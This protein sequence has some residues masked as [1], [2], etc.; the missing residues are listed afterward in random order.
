MASFPTSAVKNCPCSATWSVR[1]TSCQVCAKTRSRSSS[2]YTGSLYRRAGM[3]DARAMLGSKGKTRG[4]R[5]ERIDAVRGARSCLRSLRSLRSLAALLE[6]H[7]GSRGPTAPQV[8]EVTEVNEADD[9]HRRPH[10][11]A[12]HHP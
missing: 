12:L 5:M 11:Y 7:G 8:N 4:M 1:P 2:R 10:H 3:V 6:R 9:V